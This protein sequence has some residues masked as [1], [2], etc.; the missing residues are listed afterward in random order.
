MKSKL[1]I[2]ITILVIGYPSNLTRGMAA[3][4][5]RAVGSGNS[6]QVLF[7]PDDLDNLLAPVALYPDPLVAQILPAATFPDQIDEAAQF[8]QSNGDP[9][10]IDMQPWDM[11]VQAL[12]HYPR[13]INM[14]ASR[15]DWTTELGQAY[16]NQPDDVMNAIQ[17]L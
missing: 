15:L 8:L 10:A 12:A 11:S 3:A 6:A 7:S 1:I 9:N 13:V 17:R 4:D 14:M 2:A 5:P 16:V